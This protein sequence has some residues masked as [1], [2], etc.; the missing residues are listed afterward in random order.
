MRVTKQNYFPV[1]IASAGSQPATFFWVRRSL[2]SKEEPV[3]P[4][5]GCW[6]KY[7][8]HLSDSLPTMLGIG[9]WLDKHLGSD[10]DMPE[11]C[12]LGGN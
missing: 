8:W 2:L 3:E 11:P 10:G 5:Q 9:L 12:Y 1:L 7:S 6:E 4:L